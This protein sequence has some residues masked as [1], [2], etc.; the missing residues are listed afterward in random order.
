MAG[1]RHLL[2]DVLTVAG[3]E[4]AESLRTRRALLLL[5]LFC[6]GTVAGTWAFTAFLRTV[7]AQLVEALGLDAG[8]ALE[9]LNELHKRGV[10]R[11]EN[12]QG[13][14]FFTAS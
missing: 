9:Y 10:I 13:K 14:T 5:I 1:G 8:D 3:Q 6:G 7:E 2:R 12:K 4:L 11:S